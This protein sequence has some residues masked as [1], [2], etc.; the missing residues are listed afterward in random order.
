MRISDWSSD[1]CSSDLRRAVGSLRLHRHDAES[2]FERR[3]LSADRL[4]ADDTD[5]RR[6]RNAE[7][8]PRKAVPWSGTAEWPALRE[9]GRQSTRRDQRAAA[10]ENGRASCRERVC[11]SV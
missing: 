8:S 1:V 6:W 4:K 5:I 11:Q 3:A 2:A 9:P 7:L 10:K